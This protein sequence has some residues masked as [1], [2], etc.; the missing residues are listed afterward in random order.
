MAEIEK[1]ETKTKRNNK[2]RR[3]GKRKRI[4]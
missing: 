2:G 1:N 4:F 3:E